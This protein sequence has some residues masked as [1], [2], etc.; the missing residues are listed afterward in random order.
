MPDSWLFLRGELARIHHFANQTFD[1]VLQHG[2][3]HNVARAVTHSRNPLCLAQPG[4]TA[5]NRTSRV[6]ESRC[7]EERTPAALSV[8][9][10]FPPGNPSEMVTRYCGPSPRI[11]FGAVDLHH[12]KRVGRPRRCAD[13][14]PFSEKVPRTRQSLPYVLEPDGDAQRARQRRQP[15]AAQV[16]GRQ[17]PSCRSR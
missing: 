4:V 5:E 12:A 2:R 14:P 1:H 9:D 17:S 8:Y 13:D 15:P 10:E 3:A 7:G 6:R 16:R 11:G